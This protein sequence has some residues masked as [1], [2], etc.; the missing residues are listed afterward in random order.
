ME[1]RN[2]VWN[3][4]YTTVGRTTTK[5]NAHFVPRFFK[6]FAGSEH[7]EDPLGGPHACSTSR[8]SLSGFLRHGYKKYL[9]I[10]EV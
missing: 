1:L 6:L 9:E 3:E 8:F 4:L 2:S 5:I 10:E 7:T